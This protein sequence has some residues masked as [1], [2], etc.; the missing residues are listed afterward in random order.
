[1]LN[2]LVANAICGA[3]GEIAQIIVMYPMDTLKVQCQAQG[4]C[5]RGVLSGLRARH[6]GPVQT[7]RSMYAGCGSAATCSAIIG[8][9]YLVTFYHTK[10]LLTR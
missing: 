7:L 2:P 10:G 6:L 3:V 8:A 5:V 1:M 9:A 4:S